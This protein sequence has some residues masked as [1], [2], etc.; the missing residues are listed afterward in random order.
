MDSISCFGVGKLQKNK[1][2]VCG[3]PFSYFYPK[4]E[5]MNKWLKI[6]ILGSILLGV[7]FILFKGALD[8]SASSSEHG[9]T[10]ETY[11]SEFGFSFDY[12]S[13]LEVLDFGRWITLSPSGD[14]ELNERAQ[15]ILSLGLNDEESTAEEWLLGDGGYSHKNYGDYYKITISGQN[16]VYTDG[17]M[18][19]VVNTPDNNYRLSIADIP[20]EDGSRLFSE[21]GHVVESLR[22][23]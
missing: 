2:F 9:D 11:H 7:G 8:G 1:F 15:I 5:R 22:F 12:P 13:Y 17:G 19:V 3:S 20:A 14:T 16:A 10:F 4:I 21:M 18:W 6:V 23:K